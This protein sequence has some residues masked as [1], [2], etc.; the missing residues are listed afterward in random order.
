M[1][2]VNELNIEQIPSSSE[3]LKRAINQALAQFVVV[4]IPD[5]EPV[6]EW[7]EPLPYAFIADEAFR[8]H[9]HLLKPYPRHGLNNNRNQRIFNYRLSYARQMVVCTFGFLAAT[10]R[11]FHTPILVYPA[12]VDKIVNA[13]AVLHNL[14]RI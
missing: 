3:L 4:Q 13:A 14:I 5:N 12:K 8:L 11:I 10:F 1:N 2:N 9:Q 6:T 7:G